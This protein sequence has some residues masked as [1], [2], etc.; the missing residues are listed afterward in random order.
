MF[1]H[2]GTRNSGPPAEI[3]FDYHF[4]LPTTNDRVPQVYVEQS[5]IVNL[6]PKDPVVLHKKKPS[7]DH[8]NG[9]DRL[10]MATEDG[11]DSMGTTRPCTTVSQG[12]GLHRRAQARFRDEDLADK[13]VE[14]SVE[15]IEKNKCSPFFL[16]FASHDNHNLPRMPHERFH[17]KSKMGFRGDAIVELD[18]CVGELVKAIDKTRGL[19]RIPSFSFAPTTAH[20]MDDGYADG[21]L[22]KLGDHLAA[23]PYSGGKYSVYE[24]FAFALPSSPAGQER[25]ARVKYRTRWSAPPDMANSNF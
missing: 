19:G 16:F 18:W 14:K 2:C 8:P 20:I 9:I 15:W 1:G 3:G 4:L 24:G 21:A 10:A 7:P 23:A 6:D 12:L 11:L 13:W 17:G 22:E 25:F 5:R